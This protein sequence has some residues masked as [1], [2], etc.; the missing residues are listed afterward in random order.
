M[1]GFE[2]FH[3]FLFGPRQGGK[4]GSVTDAEDE[5]QHRQEPTADNG[6]GIFFLQS[7]ASF[8]QTHISFKLDSNLGVRY[9]AEKPVEQLSSGSVG[10]NKKEKPLVLSLWREKQKQIRNTREAD[11]AE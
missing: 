5:T 11:M 6:K 9:S 8:S 7:T 1:S 2:M 4:P 3:L 10:R